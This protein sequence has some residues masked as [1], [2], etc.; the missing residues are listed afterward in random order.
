M[1]RTDGYNGYVLGVRCA[2][3]CSPLLGF[4]CLQRQGQALRLPAA[5]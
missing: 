4:S 5:A 3:F 2:Q 1:A